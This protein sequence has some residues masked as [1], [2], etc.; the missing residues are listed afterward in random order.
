MVDA[1]EGQSCPLMERQ[2]TPTK[3]TLE[4]TATHLQLKISAPETLKGYTVIESV[5]YQNGLNTKVQ[6]VFAMRKQAAQY[7]KRFA[8]PFTDETQDGKTINP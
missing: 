4:K 1:S 3:I 5:P 2:M 7:A 6:T 8:I